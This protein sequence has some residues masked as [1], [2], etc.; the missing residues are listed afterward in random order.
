MPLSRSPIAR[1]ASSKNALGVL[2]VSI[3][4]SAM[5]KELEDLVS[6]MGR[7][8]S[9]ALSGICRYTFARVLGIARLMLRSKEDAEELAYEVYTNA[10]RYAKSYDP[11]RGTVI[12]WLFVMTRSRA[13]DRLRR[14]RASIPLGDDRNCP[15]TAS[16]VD[17]SLN[18][19]ELLMRLEAS[20]A[21]HHA[22]GSLSPD[23][24]RVLILAFFEGLTHQEIADVIG[25]P[26]GTVKSHVR[27]S[28][29]ACRTNWLTELAAAKPRE[30]SRITLRQE[31]ANPRL[32]WR[33]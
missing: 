21:V 2:E 11:S 3:S 33:L 17:E 23:R 13:L 14:R 10:W 7:G 25:L 30:R 31:S 4:H 12:A 6:S 1:T 29:S 22:L 18:P 5:E 27:R 28:L 20:A 8:E 16:L 26:L 24:R 32:P 9:A 19:E 15:L